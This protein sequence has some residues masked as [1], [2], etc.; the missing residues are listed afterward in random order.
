MEGGAFQETPRVILYSESSVSI[1]E[2][3]EVAE[4][5]KNQEEA[6]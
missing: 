5:G 1:E 2:K 6:L 4:V 3:N